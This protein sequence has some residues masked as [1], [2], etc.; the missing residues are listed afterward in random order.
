[1][2]VNSREAFGTLSLDRVRALAVKPPRGQDA[3]DLRFYDAW[4]DH[5]GYGVTPGTMLAAFRLAE[6]GNPQRQCDLFDDLIENDGHLRNLFEQR[7]QAVAGK[8]WVIQ[9]DGSEKESTVGA[10]VLG[11]ALRRI[12][13]IPVFEHL[14]SFNRYGFAAVEIDWDVVN[15]EGRDWVVPVALTPVP[16]RRFRFGS[17]S[18]LA[19]S[20]LDELRL[21][22]DTGRPDGDELRPGKW[23]V[24]RRSGSL[25]AR[26]SLMRTGAWYA[27][28]KRF[29][30]RDW[31]VLSEKF[32]IPLVTAIYDEGADDQTKAVAAEIVSKMG[33]DGGAVVPRSIEIKIH[34]AAR[35][36]DNSPTHGGLLAHCNA[37][38][39]KL[40]NGSTLSND[41]AGSGGA[42]YALG[43]VHDS[44][45]WDN[46]TYDAER[47][48]EAFRGQLNGPFMR[49]NGLSA[50]SPL[51]KIQVVRDLS[52]AMRVDMAQKLQAIGVD[53]SIAQIRQET[54]FR[55]P[56]GETDKAKPVVDVK[57]TASQAGEARP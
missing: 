30:F 43:E 34:E 28:V 3:R 40:L 22:A 38:M 42:S 35:E 1:M 41:S 37:E 23:I 39:S 9:A 10:A 44:V 29:A 33:D 15:L 11:E 13:M 48:Q 7:S 14:L 50:P 6:Q 36:A 45:R 19:N 20:R 49:F 5:P 18:C 52:P 12:E 17:M 32:G 4:T 46:V 55:E 53:V 31:T 56:L 24:V 8:P 26:A 51:L 21:L 25:L 57:P 54:G 47:L 27:M 16:P 2:S